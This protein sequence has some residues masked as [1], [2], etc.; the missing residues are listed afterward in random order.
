MMEVA[1]KRNLALFKKYKLQMHLF[2]LGRRRGFSG[3]LGGAL[4]GEGTV[5]FP[6]GCV[7]SARREGGIVR[8]EEGR[9]ALTSACWGLGGYA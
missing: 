5:S 6:C 1:L 7:E 3:T 2:I 9:Q 8:G 4:G